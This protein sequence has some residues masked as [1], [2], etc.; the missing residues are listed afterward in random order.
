MG[1]EE[2]KVKF[3][4]TKLLKTFLKVVRMLSL[5]PCIY[6]KTAKGYEVQNVIK[7]LTYLLSS[8]KV[9]LILLFIQFNISIQIKGSILCPLFEAQAYSDFSSSFYDLMTISLLESKRS[10][11]HGCWT[12]KVVLDSF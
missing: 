6:R 3:S 1:E 2:K 11:M 12:Y 10:R 7:F 4:C 8:C 5:M 9:A